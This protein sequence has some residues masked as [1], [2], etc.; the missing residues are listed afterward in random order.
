MEILLIGA[1]RLGNLAPYLKDQGAHRITHLSGRKVAHQ[2]TTFEWVERVDAVILLT[3]FVS[4]TLARKVK[5]IAKDSKVPFI[6]TPR[7]LSYLQGILHRYGGLASLCA[8][9]R[10][11]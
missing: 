8:G 4:H 9:F 11:G 5:E 1:D 2:R 3:D 10:G 6:A 7:S